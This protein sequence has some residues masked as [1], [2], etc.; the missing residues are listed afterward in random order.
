MDSLSFSIFEE[1]VTIRMVGWLQLL[2][3]S[4]DRLTATPPLGE[5]PVESMLNT[6]LLTNTKPVGPKE[7]QGSEARS[8]LP[9]ELVVSPGMTTVFQV[10][11][12]SRLTPV[13]IPN[14]PP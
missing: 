2:P 14:A 4:V 12:P 3:P 8:K 6:R 9:P 13:T 11:P 10:S 7:T 5:L 1:V